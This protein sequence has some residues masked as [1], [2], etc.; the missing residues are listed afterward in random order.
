[1]GLKY[2]FVSS[3]YP[4]IL[5]M[6]RYSSAAVAAIDSNNRSA[7]RHGFSSFFSSGRSSCASLNINIIAKH[8]Y[9]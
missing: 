4:H 1:M 2:L 6:H 8:H 5:A 7:L 3:L 9:K